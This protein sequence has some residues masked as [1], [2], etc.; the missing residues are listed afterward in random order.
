[1]SSIKL[2][3]VEDVDSE[4][5][6]LLSSARR[7]EKEFTRP[8]EIISCKSVDEALRLIDSSFD[9]AIIDLKLAGEG[10]EGNKVIEF[11]QKQ[12]RI[13]TVI[14][15]G[16]PQNTDISDGGVRVFKKGETA[17]EELFDIFH[18]TYQ[19]GVTRILGG[20]GIIE[21]AM[22]RVF[23]ESVVPGLE[24]WATHAAS[25]R[26]TEAALLRFVVNHLLELLEE[27]AFCFPEEMYIT[28]F[29]SSKLKTGQIVKEK[30]SDDYFIVL[31]PACDLVVHNGQMKTDRI[32]VAAVEANAPL[33]RSAKET[34]RRTIAETASDDDKIRF[35]KRQDKAQ[36]DLSR[37]ISNSYSNYYHY[38]PR[39]VRFRGG[40]I[41]FRR[42]AVRADAP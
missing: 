3:V 25:G 41:N 28:P 18:R 11:I 30:S 22:T 13:P 38:L 16:T 10:D 2:I 19:T 34:L 8:L 5:E 14:F 26:E 20:R 23:W 40:F 4:I 9:G 31:S 12:L 35:A 42:V 39:N 1:M 27:P 29:D 15:T 36:S 6:L 17:H 32:L 21:Q 37:L 7:Y 24:S 33:A